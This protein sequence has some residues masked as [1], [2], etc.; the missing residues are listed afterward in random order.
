MAVVKGIGIGSGVVVTVVCWDVK[1]VE[2]SKDM[3]YGEWLVL[4]RKRGFVYRAYELG[5]R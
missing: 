4:K 2:Y 5:Y 3:T 1:G